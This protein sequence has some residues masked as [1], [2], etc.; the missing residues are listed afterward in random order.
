MKYQGSRGVA[1]GDRGRECN[2]LPEAGVLGRRHQM[3][4]VE[5]R[6]ACRKEKGADADS[7]GGRG[8][9]NEDIRC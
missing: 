2:Q 6:G 8:G 7:G 5:G 1:S 3:G 9:E 4:N